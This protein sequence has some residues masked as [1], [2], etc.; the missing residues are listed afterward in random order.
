MDRR[1]FVALGIAGGAQLGG[2]VPSDPRV[3]ARGSGQASVRDRFPR[4]ENRRF[5]NAAAGTPMG[6]F[7][8]DGARRYME[9]WERGPGGPEAAY[10]GEVM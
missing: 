4:L 2:L 7:A 3:R 9:F 5:V 6:D 8:A 1:D 10:F